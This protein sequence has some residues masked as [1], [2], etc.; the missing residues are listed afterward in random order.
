MALLITLQ[1]LLALFLL[2]HSGAMMTDG[3]F[4]RPLR[5]ARLKDNTRPS[6]SGKHQPGVWSAPII[7]RRIA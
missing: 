6:H 1:R 3:S 5:M 7:R 4:L 2:Q